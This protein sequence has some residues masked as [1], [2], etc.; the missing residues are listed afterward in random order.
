MIYLDNAATSPASAASAMAVMKTMCEDFYNPAS[1][2]GP[3]IRVENQVESARRSLAAYLGHPADSLYFT[4][5]GTESDNIA[6]LGTADVQ[7]KGIWRYICGPAEHPAVYE[8]FQALSRQ[9][10]EVLYLHCGEDGSLDLGELA[11][12]IDEKTVL[13]SIMHVN[14]EFGAVTDLS[15]VAEVVRKTNPNTLLHSDGVQAALHLPQMLCPVD[16]YSL[17]AHKFHG[18][19]GVGALLRGP[20]ARAK[21][22]LGGGQEGGFRSGTTNSSGI[23]GMSVALEE[24]RDTLADRLARMECCKAHLV[25]GLGNFEDVLIN[26]P[27]PESAAPHIL[28]VS[29]MGIRG[30]VLL[31]ALEEQGVLVSTGSACSSK[32]HGINRI[33]AA[34]GVTGPRAESALRFSFSH[35][36]TVSEMDDVLNALEELIPFHRKFQR[37]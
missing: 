1:L 21:G 31:H 7:R 20:R 30:E 12:L 13:V 37:R 2:Y 28:N 14:N 3:A 36:N 27:R 29:F 33:L 23:L 4:S 18:P 15:A 25:Q 22:Q 24:A 6:I 9:G 35:L 5:G 17:S 26:G 11:D 16:L 8:C 10:Q 32:K 19:K 34:I